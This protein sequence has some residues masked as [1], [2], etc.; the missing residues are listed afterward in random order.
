[1]EVDRVVDLTRIVAL[2]MYVCSFKAS[3]ATLLG[4]QTHSKRFTQI[5][6]LVQKIYIFERNQW[7]FNTIRCSILQ[8]TVPYPVA[9][10]QNTMNH[11]YDNPGITALIKNETK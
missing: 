1:M 4:N 9:T 3:P 2:T 7:F 10:L 5:G 6:L 11:K 8:D